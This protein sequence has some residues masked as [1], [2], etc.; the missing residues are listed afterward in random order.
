MLTRQPMEGRARDGGLRMGEMERDCLISHGCAN[1]LRD[2]LFLNR[3]V[4]FND[5]FTHLCICSCAYTYR[6]C[7]CTDR[8][9]S[10]TRHAMHNET[11]CM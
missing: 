8:I 2:R 1:F 10:D 4:V 6:D 5:I 7:S 3:L 11:E 9:C